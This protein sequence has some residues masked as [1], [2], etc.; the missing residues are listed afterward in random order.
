MVSIALH[1]EPYLV[2]FVHLFNAFGLLL[3]IGIVAMLIHKASGI[4]LIPRLYGNEHGYL[5][6]LLLTA[7]IDWLVGGIV[8]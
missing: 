5:M 2:L 7:A 6:C 8:L 1:P 4:L 3:I